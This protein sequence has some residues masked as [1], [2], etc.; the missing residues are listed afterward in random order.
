MK[1]FDHILQG[2]EATYENA[3][4]CIEGLD[5]SEIPVTEQAR[6]THSER[7]GDPCMDIQVWYDYGA[8]YYFFEDLEDTQ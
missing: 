7:V 6:P 2:H 4:E 5:W 8:D 3:C 1:L